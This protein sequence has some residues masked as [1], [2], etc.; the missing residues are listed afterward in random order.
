MGSTV[1]LHVLNRMYNIGLGDCIDEIS[2][3]SSKFH[4]NN[5]FSKL[6]YSDLALIEELE[7]Y[8]QFSSSDFSD[9][10]VLDYFLTEVRRDLRILDL[11]NSNPVTQVFELKGCVV[12]GVDDK[13]VTEKDIKSWTQ[14]FPSINVH[15]VQGGHFFMKDRGMDLYEILN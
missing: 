10:E 3:L 14:F 13:A 4:L 5:S 6:L 15:S 2:V 11:L 12:T 1:A 9:P 7:R 8:G